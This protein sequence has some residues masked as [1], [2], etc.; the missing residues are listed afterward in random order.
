MQRVVVRWGRLRTL[1]T[2]GDGWLGTLGRKEGRYRDQSIT[3]W[4]PW[5]TDGGPWET[6]GTKGDG[7]DD[8][9]FHMKHVYDYHQKANPAS[10]TSILPIIKRSQRLCTVHSK[11]VGSPGHKVLA[12][13]SACVRAPSPRR[14]PSNAG[15]WRASALPLAGISCWLGRPAAVDHKLELAA[16]SLP[17]AQMGSKRLTQA[18]ASIVYPNDDIT[19][20]EACKGTLRHRLDQPCVLANGETEALSTARKGELD[21]VPAGFR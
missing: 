18:Q 14:T 19:L 10:Q 1:G 16:L 4:G 5:G 17:P 12:R 6:V 9:Q 3:G 15:C 21:S 7:G 13:R 20:L 11:G 8:H 2:A